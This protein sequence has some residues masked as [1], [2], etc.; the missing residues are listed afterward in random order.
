F[1]QRNTSPPLHA[2][3][4]G[5][6]LHNRIPG[7]P[8]LVDVDLRL[9]IMDRYDGY[10]QVLTLANP[11]IEVAAGPDLSPELARLAN[12][13]MAEIVSRHPERFPAFVASLPM[14]NPDAAVREIDRAID[15]LQ[16]TGV[17]IYTNVAG[18]P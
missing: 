13:G 7:I 5:T 14:N 2:A 12:D 18:R 4:P 16:A 3:R 15:D 11:P 8:A 17:Q 6:A 1:A 10:V 9:R